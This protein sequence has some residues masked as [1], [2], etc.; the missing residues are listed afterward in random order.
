M[1]VQKFDALILQVKCDYDPNAES[2]HGARS[3]LRGAP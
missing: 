1:A 2:P 3:T